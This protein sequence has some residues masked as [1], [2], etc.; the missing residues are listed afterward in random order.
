LKSS[1]V[2][3]T[4]VLLA[5]TTTLAAEYLQHKPMR[6]GRTLTGAMGLGIGLSL[7]DAGSPQ[8]AEGLAYLVIISSVLINGAPIFEAVSKGVK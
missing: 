1:Q 8:V 6:Y 4:A 5:A 3:L 2:I 7:L